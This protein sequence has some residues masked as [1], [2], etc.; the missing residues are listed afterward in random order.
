MRV[1]L[2]KKEL[3][4]YYLDDEHWIQNAE[5]A[6]AF[7]SSSQALEFCRQKQ[8]EGVQIVLKFDSDRYDLILPSLVSVG[9]LP[10]TGATS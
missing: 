5:E 6:K 4:G 8:W 1:L 7:E 9:D 3:G 10:P 2:K